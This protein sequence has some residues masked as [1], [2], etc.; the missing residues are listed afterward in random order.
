MRGTARELFKLFKFVERGDLSQ[1][2]VAKK[3]AI[4]AVYDEMQEKRKHSDTTELMVEINRII[5]DAITVTKDV[6]ALAENRRFDISSIDFER[7]QQEFAHIKNKNLLIKDLK[8]LVE[9][10]LHRMMQTN[11]LRIDYYERY[12]EIINEYNAEQNKAAI[13]KTFIDLMAMTK[14]LDEEAKRFVRE[15][16]E[17][18][19][20][21]AMFDLLCKDTLTPQEIKE[22]KALSKTLLD[23]VKLKIAELDH[24][25]EKPETLDIVEVLIRDTLFEELPESYEDMEIV[26]YRQIVFDHVRK[27]YPAA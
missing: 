5:S 14:A 3:N 6:Q 18:D 2:Q 17:S 22:I 13:E 26:A 19:E 24:W 23:T 20:E 8:D 15:G 1:E 16:F 11:P 7:L 12:Q 27:T 4:S 10:R 21:L 25:T 9:E